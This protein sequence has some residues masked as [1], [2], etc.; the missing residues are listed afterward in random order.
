MKKFQIKAKEKVCKKE[1]N[2]DLGLT[3][4]L[5]KSIKNKIDCWI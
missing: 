2:K 1:T 3:T 5:L 4:A